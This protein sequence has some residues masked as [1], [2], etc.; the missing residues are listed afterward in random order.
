MR[1]R[2]AQNLKILLLKNKKIAK[3]ARY[4][5]YHIWCW[6]DGGQHPSCVECKLSDKERTLKGL[7]VSTAKVSRA[8]SVGGYA[9]YFN[10][11]GRWNAGHSPYP[12]IQDIAWHIFGKEYPLSS[13]PKPESYDD[14]T[15]WKKIASVSITT[16]GKIYVDGEYMGIFEEFIK[17]EEPTQ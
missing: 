3:A 17:P 6:T 14:D 11:L 8:W 7:S 2:K 1:L 15:T 12:E 5:A 13:F 4:C 9:G 16:E 10:V